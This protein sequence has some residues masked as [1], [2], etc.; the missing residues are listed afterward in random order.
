MRSFDDD[1][2][3]RSK[4]TEEALIRTECTGIVSGSRHCIYGTSRFQRGEDGKVQAT[5]DLLWESVTQEP[6]F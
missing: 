2:E 5:L 6:I 3:E 1:I 4:R